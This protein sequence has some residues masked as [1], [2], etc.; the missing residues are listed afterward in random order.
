MK[1][2]ILLTLLFVF[3]V[4]TFGQT[5]RVKVYFG[6]DKLNPNTEDCG[7]VFAV[8]REL[9]KTKA[10]AK[11]ALEELFKGVSAAEKMQGYSS[12]FSVETKAILI[13]VKIKN[14]AAYVNFKNTIVEKLGNATSSCGSQIF[15]SQIETTLKQFPAVKKVFY[16]IEGKPKDFYDWMQ[17][18]ECPKE[19]KNCSGKNF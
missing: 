4:V 19:L 17:V 14:G 18:G 15:G 2:I 10:V 16:A 3:P 9:P 1:K 7:R 11:A 13:G 8:D 5:T 12:L 6:N